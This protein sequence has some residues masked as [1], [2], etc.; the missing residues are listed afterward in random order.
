MGL[1]WG[2][3]EGFPADHEA[4]PLARMPAVRFGYTIDRSRARSLASERQAA[5]ASN[6]SRIR[7]LSSAPLGHSLSGGLF[8]AR[9]RVI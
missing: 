4:D 9:C 3:H 1:H 6:R 2:S 8:F 7:L 5:R